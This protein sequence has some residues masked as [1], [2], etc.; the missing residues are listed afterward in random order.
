MV[1]NKNESREI[2]D[3]RERKK[4]IL[5]SYRRSV[6]HM[7]FCSEEIDRLQE[8]PQKVTQIISA[9]PTSAPDGSKQEM[10]LEQ[11]ETM[12]SEYLKS[13]AAAMEDLRRVSDILDT[14]EGTESIAMKY[15]YITGLTWES[16]AE[17]L[18]YSVRRMLDLQNSALDKLQI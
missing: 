4:E 12:K 1:G 5:R 2:R 11:L 6:F 18:E 15:K 9:M 13:F 8:L 17:R 16:I 14:L 7:D 10:V 3:E